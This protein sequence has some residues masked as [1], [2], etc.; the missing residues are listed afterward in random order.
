MANFAESGAESRRFTRSPYTDEAPIRR[1]VF[2]L[3]AHQATVAHPTH[4][5]E[6]HK[7][8][9]GDAGSS[10]GLGSDILQLAPAEGSRTPAR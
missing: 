7:K 1:V 9:G 6:K 4:I 10:V 2:D 3:D 8:A 5:H